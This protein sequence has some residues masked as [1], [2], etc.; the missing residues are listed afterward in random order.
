[1]LKS[2]FLIVLGFVLFHLVKTNLL[3]KT[4]KT[5][6]KKERTQEILLEIDKNKKHLTPKERRKMEKE[7]TDY[8][9]S[10]FSE[11]G[12]REIISR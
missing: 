10:L 12:S 5:V 11:G 7:L 4:K 1:M 6:K 9:R 8:F 3:I 2:F